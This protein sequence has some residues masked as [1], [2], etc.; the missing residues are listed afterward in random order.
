MHSESLRI[1]FKVTNIA[2]QI[3]GVLVGYRVITNVMP[4]TLTTGLL[5]VSPIAGVFLLWCRDTIDTY[6][7][8]TKE[9]SNQWND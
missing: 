2:F 8:T 3:I 9:S 1:A 4:L 6:R 7:Q 5:I